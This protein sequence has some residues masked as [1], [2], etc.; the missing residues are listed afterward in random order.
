MEKI[1]SVIAQTEVAITMTSR[2]PPTTTTVQCD[3]AAIVGEQMIASL[4]EIA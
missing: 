3:E 4:E 1:E 2:C